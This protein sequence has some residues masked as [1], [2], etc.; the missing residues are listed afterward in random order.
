M[1]SFAAGFSDRTALPVTVRV[2]EVTDGLP[3]ELRRTMLRI[4]QEALTNAH[5]HAEATRVVVTLRMTSGGTTLCIG[6]DGRGMRRPAPA[7][8]PTLGVGIPGMRIRL[9][10]FGGSLRIRSSRRGTIVRAFIPHEGCAV[11]DRSEI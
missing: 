8:L 10:Q 5:R 6:D 2:A 4:F 3:L 11:F 9:H 7:G 1:R